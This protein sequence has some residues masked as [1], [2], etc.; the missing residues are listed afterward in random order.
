MENGNGGSGTVWM[1]DGLGWEVMGRISGMEGLVWRCMEGKGEIWSL[2]IK[3][4]EEEMDV[5]NLEE[6]NCPPSIEDQDV[7]MD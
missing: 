4:M 1:V 7:S 6:F 3:G 5:A 2:E